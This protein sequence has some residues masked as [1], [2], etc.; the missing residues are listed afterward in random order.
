MRKIV[1]NEIVKFLLIQ[2]IEDG[3]DGLWVSGL[4]DEVTIITVGQEYV[5][6]GQNVNVQ[7]SEI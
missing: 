2:I 4:P 6:N 1:E 7:L 3:L 5:I